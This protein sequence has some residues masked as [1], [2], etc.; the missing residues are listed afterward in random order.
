MNL[1]MTG[2]VIGVLHRPASPIQQIG[3]F[4]PSVAEFSVC[5]KHPVQYT[6][7]HASGKGWVGSS[8]HSGQVCDRPMGGRRGDLFASATSFCNACSAS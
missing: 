5:F 2:S 6:C 7:R 8:K 1:S 4:L 3:I